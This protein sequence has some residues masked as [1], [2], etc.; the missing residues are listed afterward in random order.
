MNII[1]WQ[2]VISILQSALIVSLAKNHSVKLVVE[3]E[4]SNE[5]K[6]SGWH[7]PDMGNATIVTSPSNKD[8]DKILRDNHDA[9]H[10]FSGIDAY[11]MVYSAFKKSISLKLKTIVYLE[12]YRW[13][14]IKGCLRQFKYSFL[15][16]KYGKHVGAWLVTGDAGR[17]C[18]T[19]AGFSP[20][21]IFDW[22]YFT[23]NA[24]IL[25]INAEKTLTPKLLFVGSIDE[26][27]NILSLVKVSKTMK[28]KF[29]HFYIVGTGHL[30]D[31]LQ[32]M[33]KDD[34]NISY[35]GVKGNHEVHVLMQSCD[36]FVL[37]SIFDGWGAVVNEA[38]Q[39]GMRV[40][41]SENCGASVLLDGECRGETF[42]FNKT[43]DL[44]KVLLKW[45]EKGSLSAD[46][47]NRIKEWSGN[48]IS[49]NVV[50]A[51]FLEICGFI[52]HDSKNNPTAPW[53]K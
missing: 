31:E 24:D 25:N 32:E 7:I 16:I 21:K 12:P 53:L 22:G 9:I 43:N 28:D 35:L 15:N 8:I 26:R 34:D 51:Y 48:N 13:M 33:I 41:S 30:V 40:I 44:K 5:R 47:R 52:Y 20:S 39:N 37:P 14:G 6:K 2:N 10:V 45:L 50:C 17:R 19:K 49:G 27:K 3:K 23:E 1:F 11:P 4:M 18:Y 46:E 36:I 38:L 42:G 29:S